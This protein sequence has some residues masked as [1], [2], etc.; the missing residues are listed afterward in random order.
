MRR[1]GFFF[2]GGGG[3][4]AANFFFFRGRNVHQVKI[5]KLKNICFDNFAFFA[6]KLLKK[7]SFPGHFGNHKLPS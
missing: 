5:V 1:I 7:S 6:R 2:W 3:G 4:R